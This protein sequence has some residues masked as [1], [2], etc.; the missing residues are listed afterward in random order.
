MKIF[1]GFWLIQFA[2]C[3]LFSFSMSTG[4]IKE[5]FMTLAFMEIFRS[6]IML[7]TYLLGL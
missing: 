6:I 3:L 5:A 7:G 1:M 2:L 4:D